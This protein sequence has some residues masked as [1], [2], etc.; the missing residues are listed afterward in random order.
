MYDQEDL[1]YCIDAQ[2]NASF[3]VG[4][5]PAG[6]VEMF[7]IFAK[8]LAFV[9]F[10]GQTSEEKYCTDKTCY[11]PR[12]IRMEGFNWDSVS[13]S[14]QGLI[15]TWGLKVVGAVALLVVGLFVIKSI[16]R[17][18]KGALL[19][20]KLDETLVPF[21]TGMVYYFLLI[22]L[23]VAVLSLFGIE[24]TSV[25][26]VLGAA[27][28]AVGLAL[29]GTL[30]NF[31]SGIMLLIFRPF[32]AGDYVEVGGVA[33]S[34]T[35]VGIFS[36]RLTTPDNVLI[37]VPN[38]TIYGQVIKNYSANENRRCDL[39]VGISYSDDISKAMAV[40]HQVLKADERVLAD[41]EPMVAVSE[42]ADSSVNLVVR[43]WCKKE[44]YWP[45]RFDLT[46][47]IKEQLETNGLSIPFPQR[48]VHVFKS[49]NIA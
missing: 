1:S 31:A 9:L 20:S 19:S 22:V 6:L 5:S 33:G 11:L 15:S 14:I 43:P 32:R 27:G 23:L 49:G 29:Q 24:T 46:R 26:A 40:I 35:E 37:N 3:L 30:S 38:S 13:A 10:W 45:L 42:L 12:R 16:R 21:L 48:D 2:S 47:V 7:R 34:V 28:L 4:S 39:V 41:P 36:S 8:G 18:I 25:I 44:V 17:L